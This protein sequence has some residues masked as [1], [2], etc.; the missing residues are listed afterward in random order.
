MRHARPYQSLLAGLAT[1]LASGCA[2]LPS[3]QD[4]AEPVA[5]HPLLLDQLRPDFL[6]YDGMWRGY[7][8][9]R[10]NERQLDNQIMECRKSPSSCLPLF[11]AWV[12]TIDMINELPAD[13]KQTRAQR[14]LIAI[15]GLISFNFDKA[16]AFKALFHMD[17]WLQTPTETLVDQKGKEICGDFA[18]LVYETAKRVGLGADVSLIG[19]VEAG[20]NFHIVTAVKINGQT[21]IM[22]AIANKPTGAET[23]YVATYRSYLHGFRFNDFSNVW[24]SRPFYPLFK[25]TEQGTLLLGGIS[26]LAN[27]ALTNSQVTAAAGRYPFPT[28]DMAPNTASRISKLMVEI[29]VQVQKSK[30]LLPLPASVAYQGLCQ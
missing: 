29:D 1:L 20:L 12:K 25:M 27:A 8:A 9:A 19:G 4:S 28:Q 7:L 30:G 17:R 5:K 2:S 26:N 6:Y 11:Q 22:D 10:G 18:V 13:D 14:M 23:T 3:T 15:A 24:L 21:Y 16:T